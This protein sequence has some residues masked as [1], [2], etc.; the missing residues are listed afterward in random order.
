MWGNE[1]RPVMCGL[2]T[3]PVDPKTGKVVE[4]STAEV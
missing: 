4:A 2:G 1:F 3:P